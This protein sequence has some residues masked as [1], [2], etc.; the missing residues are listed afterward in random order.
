MRKKN[1]TSFFYLEKGILGKDFF[2]AP[3]YLSIKLGWQFNYVFPIWEK[4]KNFPLN[5]RNANLVPINSES[6]F[7]FSLW[8]ERASI[9]YLLRNAKNIDLLFLVWLNPRSLLLSLIYKTLNK[10]GFVFIK[11]DFNEADL[12]KIATIAKDTNGV[13]IC[14]KEY[15]HSHIN[16]LSCETKS[17]FL[18]IR[19]GLLGKTLNNKIVLLPNG[20]DETA[21][22]EAN[23]SIKSF[24]EK[25]NIILVVG[26]IGD[27]NKNHELLLEAIKNINLK[28]WKIIFVGPIENNFQITI[29]LF[30]ENYPQHRDVIELVGPVYNSNDLWEYYNR[31]KVFLLTSNK[32]G[33]PNVFAEALRFGCYIVTTRVSS[34]SEITN[35]ETVG[36]IIDIGNINQLEHFFH[37]LLAGKVDI[38]S[39]Y[40][41]ALDLS[42]TKFLWPVNISK[43]VNNSNLN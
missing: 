9:L 40:D 15:L 12:S 39:N 8:K 36:K 28:D 42:M 11:G 20:F 16:M 24:E 13:K 37:D 29:A 1:I 18:Q 6:E 26:R 38:S 5:Y 30:K 34:A 43:I 10:K 17:S 22:I 41:K 7:N 3:L 4:N 23:I 2:L 14:I 31:S 27:D 32:E 25:E 33:F 35:E 19:N 21:R